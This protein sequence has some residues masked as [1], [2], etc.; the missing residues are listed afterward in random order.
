V[1]E[2]PALGGTEREL[3]DALLDLAER[4]PDGWTLVGGQM[5]LLRALEQGRVPPRVTRDLDVLADLRARPA[6]LPRIL[7]TPPNSTLRSSSQPP[8]NPATASNAETSR[9]TCSRPTTSARGPTCTPW[10]RSQRSPSPAAPTRSSA[11]SRSQFGSTGAAPSSPAPTSQARSSS[12]PRRQDLS[13]DSA[14]NVTSATWRCSF[15][16]GRPLPPARRTRP[17]QRTPHRHSA[18]PRR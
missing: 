7:T 10:A 17:A 13:M 5:V 16:G 2:L 9:S 15:T 12:K 4:Q 3:W 1:I 6:A 8:T 18:S 11:A 14:Q